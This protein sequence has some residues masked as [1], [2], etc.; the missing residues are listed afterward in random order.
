[1]HVELHD[2][3]HMNLLGLL[4]RGLLESRLANDRLRTRISRLKGDVLLSAGT[5]SITLRFGD[6]R[7]VLLSEPGRPPRSTVRGEVK[8]LLEMVTGGGL[9]GHLLSRRVRI[10]GCPLLL[11]RILPLFR[12]KP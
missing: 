8:P 12:E 10:G 7:V 9:L 5:M 3:E 2:P 6:G 4:T 1:M 11:L